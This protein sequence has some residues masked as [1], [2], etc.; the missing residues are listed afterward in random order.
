VMPSSAPLA[1]RRDA[2]FVAAFPEGC[3]RIRWQVMLLTSFETF[4]SK[5]ANAHHFPFWARSPTNL[6]R[7]A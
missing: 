5:R 2:H 3:E 4:T 1:L 6:F 7:Q